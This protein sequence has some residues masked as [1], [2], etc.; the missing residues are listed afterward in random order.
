MKFKGLLLVLWFVCGQAVLAQDQSVTL[1]GS[2]PYTTSITIQGL[3][4]GCVAMVGSDPSTIVV[5]GCPLPVSVVA[6]C[7]LAS[8]QVGQSVQCNAVVTGATNSNVT[9]TSSNSAIAAV[10][11]TGLVTGKSAGA[12]VN[13]IATSL[14]DTTKF[15]T[16]ALAVMATPVA[17]TITQDATLPVP[18]SAGTV[19]IQPT[20]DPPVQ[21]A[22]SNKLVFYTAK[23]NYQFS[24]NVITAGAYTLSARLGT[25]AAVT[26][27]SLTVHWEMPAG[28]IVSD[29]M[30]LSGT[31]QWATVP[32]TKAVNFIAGQNAL[33]LVVDTLPVGGPGFLHWFQ[34]IPAGGS[35]P[36]AH[37]VKL[38]WAPGAVS[39]AANCPAT[40]PP[41]PA[42][43]NCF[44][45]ATNY[46]IY[47]SQTAGSYTTALYVVPATTTTYTDTSVTAGQTYYYRV[48]GYSASACTPESGPS[49]EIKAVIPATMKAKKKS[50]PAKP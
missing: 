27:G 28:V 30:V 15:S 12:A 48:T 44:G 1:S 21:G 42:S 38:T 10:S 43:P 32:S 11:A 16:Y 19:T 6:S 35:V 26:S 50:K 25:D 17:T 14:Q 41:C 29:P 49:N 40:D 33:R 22:G 20:Q 18:I 36:V 8:I 45:A 37:S 39:P 13:I 46:K 24:V 34:L 9:W 31:N 7:P 2:A 4:P 3:P 23:Q 47:R 5:T